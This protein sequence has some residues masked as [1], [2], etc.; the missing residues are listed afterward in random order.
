MTERLIRGPLQEN[1]SVI[2]VRPQNQENIGLIARAMKNTGFRSLRIV[3]VERLTERAFAAAVHSGDILE[4]AV[5]LPHLAD[6][7]CDLNLIA[8]ATAK[9][10]KNFTLNSFDKASHRL[11]A[12]PPGTRIG[13]LF[14]NERTGLISNELRIANFLFT[15]PQAARQPSYNLASAVLLTLFRLTSEVPSPKKNTRRDPPIPRE[16]QTECI[17]LILEKLKDRRFIHETNAEHITEMVHSLFGRLEMTEKDR[18]LLLAIFSKG[19]DR[20]A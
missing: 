18:N 7:V 8:A 9:S 14:G 10:R 19:I 17:R 11:V 5:L 1:L 12:A 15:I 4:R 2:L 6:A 3:G 20:K 16:E 13:L